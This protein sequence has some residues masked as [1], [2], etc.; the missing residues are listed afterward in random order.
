MTDKKNASS[1]LGNT[2][3]AVIGNV[4]GLILI[5]A[6][7]LFRFTGA[8]I[9]VEHVSKSAI[10]SSEHELK[11]KDDLRNAVE[12]FSVNQEGLAAVAKQVQ[13][14]PRDVVESVSLNFLFDAT[15]AVVI[16]CA[17]KWSD[18]KVKPVCDFFADDFKDHL[19]HLQGKK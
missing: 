14:P 3:W 17:S 9:E 10:P 5:A 18:D 2:K 12:S 19:K 1:L 13:S 16:E 6:F 11:T 15:Q 4:I 8:K 7:L